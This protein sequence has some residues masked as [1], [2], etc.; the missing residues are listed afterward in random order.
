MFLD[1]NV[2]D[3]IT[4]PSSQTKKALTYSNKQLIAHEIELEKMRRDNNRR[5]IP[6]ADV[7][8]PKAKEANAKSV[9]DTNLPNHLQ[10]LNFKELK[11]KTKKVSTILLF[12]TDILVEM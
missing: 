12:V 8:A 1:P 4:F 11:P 5:G 7:S 10:K 6:T 3:I 9:G 2:D